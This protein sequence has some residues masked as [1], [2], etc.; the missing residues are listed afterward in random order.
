M[1]ATAEPRS[2]K[3]PDPHP[4]LIGETV[5]FRAVDRCWAAAIVEAGPHETAQLFV[6]PL[7]P[8]YAMPS[9]PGTFLPHHADGQ[10]TSWHRLDE[11]DRAP[12]RST[13][14]SG[15]RTRKKS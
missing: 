1:A 4:L 9:V 3:P 6:F 13:R 12:K 15:R 11:C 8:A 5:H 2:T 10:D 7:P 14:S